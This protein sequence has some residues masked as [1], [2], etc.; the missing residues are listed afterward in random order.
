MAVLWIC[1]NCHQLG[2]A[3]NRGGHSSLPCCEACGHS[4]I[5]PIGTPAGWE[6]VKK[7]G[8][9][10]DTIDLAGHR[11]DMAAWEMFPMTSRV[12]GVVLGGIGGTTCVAGSIPTG[13]LVWYALA[14]ICGVTIVMHYSA[15][16]IPPARGQK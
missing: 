3:T 13:S 4:T 8:V 11:A 16:P 9:D 2:Q 12:I 6:L 14:A 5:I 10:S 15:K 7:I 1:K